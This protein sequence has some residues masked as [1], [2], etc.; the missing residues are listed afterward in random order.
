MPSAF[1]SHSNFDKPVVRR[2]REILN[3]HG[4]QTWIDEDNVHPGQ[5]IS[6]EIQKGIENSDYFLLFLSPKAVDSGWVEREWQA[7]LHGEIQ[8]KIDRLIPIVLSDCEIPQFLKDIRYIDFRKSFEEGLAILLTTLAV[9]SE[10]PVDSSSIYNTVVGMLEDLEDEAIILP[11]AGRIFIVKT[12]KR[13]PRSGKHLRLGRQ[14]QVDGSSVPSRSLYDHVLS[15]GHSADVLYSHIDHE[16]VGADVGDLARCIAYHELNE[17][18]LGD[19][20][21]FTNL[22]STRRQKSRIQSEQRLRSVDPKMREYFAHKFIW[23]FLDVK[24]RASLDRFI[25]L[26]EDKDLPA[27]RFFQVLDKMDPIIGVWRYLHI[28][29][30]RLDQNGE[31]FLRAMSDFF[32]NP[33]PSQIVKTY[34]NEKLLTLLSFLQDIRNARSFYKDP[35][36]LRKN[37]D[38]LGFPAETRH[39]LITGRNMHFMEV[40]GRS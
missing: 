10:T 18:L 4:I 37:S 16:L 34:G 32:T 35:D 8:S 27:Y 20:P 1:L 25:N 29:R 23:M 5:R 13:L 19:I 40:K 15:L 6:S 22:N 12:L 21:S 9:Q 2:I 33:D 39:L 24:H 26:S 14:R 28:F 36:F 38:W 3:S 31:K 17:V 7:R 30:G 11:N